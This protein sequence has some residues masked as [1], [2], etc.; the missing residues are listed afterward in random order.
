MTRL[1]ALLAVVASA[2]CGPATPP[3]QTPPTSAPAP[4]PAAVPA[5]P[6]DPAPV[7]DGDV[8]EAWLHGMQILVKRVPGAELVA[9]QLYIRGGVRNWTKETAGV[10]RLALSVAASGGTRRLARDAFAR[11]LADLGSSIGSLGTDD[12]SGL[13]AKSM[14]AH[15][16]ETFGLLAEAF[17]EPALPASEVELQ[18]RFQLSRLRHELES[19]DGRLGFRLR[20]TYYHGH[21]Y[22]RRSTGTLA[23]VKR[24]SGRDLA[25]HLAGLRQ[26]SRLL[27]VVVGDVDP[28][29]VL[30]QARA[31]FGALPRGD[32]RE[33]PL[34]G[35][36]FP[37]PRLVTFAEKLPTNYI[38][39]A[40]PGPRR[41]DR[42]FAAAVVAMKVLQWR[43]FEEVRTK[44]SLSYAP[45][46]YLSAR[47]AQTMGVL[48]VSTV[49]PDAAWKV[50]TDEAR[51]L[52]REAVPAKELA[53]AKSLYLTGYLMNAQGTDGQAGLLARAQLLA[54]DWRWSRAFPGQVR[55]V[56]AAAVEA[57]AK[58]AIRSLQT[59]VLGD[60]AAIDRALFTSF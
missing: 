14:K 56:T 24:L 55:A 22:E 4:A 7:T 25:G 18:R 33:A 46:A 37:K 3:P 1:L 43:E 29:Q 30:A 17:R 40:F 6:P 31:A 60:P 58:H 23:T 48:S 10:E 50:M 38:A 12:Y 13:W 57:W 44:R 45:G 34:P 15:W 54:G 41:T 11:R 28:A 35:L 16:V 36:A 52:G 5:P 9:A 53:G 47:A 42:D 39:G 59:V 27:L 49:K 51:R 19:P 8:T 32:Y 26:T 20:E 2:A 21:P